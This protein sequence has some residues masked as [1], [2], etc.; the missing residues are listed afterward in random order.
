VFESGNCG[1]FFVLAPFKMT[2][3]DFLYVDKDFDNL[4][5]P[6]RGRIPQEH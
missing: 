6:L 4:M 3:N 5:M 1:Q 2:A